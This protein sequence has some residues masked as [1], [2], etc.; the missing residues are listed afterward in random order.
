MR[1]VVTQVDNDHAS[2]GVEIYADGKRLGVIGRGE[3]VSTE[4]PDTDRCSVRAVCGVYRKEMIVSGDAYIL[5]RWALNPS[6]MELER[7]RA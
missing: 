1:I 2:T 4:V 7:K 5:I 6:D 3:S